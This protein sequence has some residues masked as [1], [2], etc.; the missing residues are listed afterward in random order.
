MVE[1]LKTHY[2]VSER[3]A[4]Q[5]VAVARSVHRYESIADH[6][7]PLRGRLRDLASTRYRYGYRR[8]HVL[9]RREG[10]QV[11][12]HLVHR[13]Y[14]EEGLVLRPRRPRRH[15]SAARRQRPLRGASH[16]NEAWSMDFVSDEL[17]N[18]NRFRALTVVDVH[19]RECLAIGPGRRLTGDDVVRV[20]NRL[21]YTRG[22]PKRIYCDNGSEF[23]SHIL[24]LW[25]YHNQVTIEF[26]R[27]GKPTDNGHIES[28]N[29]RLRDECLNTHW[30]QSLTDAKDKIET[31]RRDYNEVRPHRALNYLT[32][33]EF[34]AQ[35]DN[36]SQKTK[37]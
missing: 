15:V 23:T 5:V 35:L 34:A 11:G 8:L 4:C 3:R 33:N 29:G 7:E 25:A 1:Y 12:K 32:P 19:T 22:T 14:C 30:F 10:Y 6:H 24:D 27:P 17:Q 26:S 21:G 20:L 37:P 31:W 36:R 28:F 2:P 16:V 13:L 18:G 9:L